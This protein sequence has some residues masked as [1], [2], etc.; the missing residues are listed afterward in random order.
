[1]LCSLPVVLRNSIDVSQHV[2]CS[3]V[4]DISSSESEDDTFDLNT[5]K[6]RPYALEPLVNTDQQS[7]TEENT[8]QHKMTYGLLRRSGTTSWC[9]CGRCKMT[10]VLLR[11]SGTTSWCTC[12]RCKMTCGLLRRSGTTSWC[13]CGRCKMT[14]VLL[15]RSGTTS[16]CTCGRCKMTYGLLRRSGTTSWCTCGRYD[17]VEPQAGVPA[18]DVK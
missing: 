7:S 15:R 17:E 2:A 14:C 9:T 10:C 12:G 6:L 18:E 1:M 13:T 16:W 11:R 5:N 3:Y 8:G 4:N